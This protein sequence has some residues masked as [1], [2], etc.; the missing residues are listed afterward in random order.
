MADA[1]NREALGRARPRGRG[2]R[3]G[4]PVRIALVS[5]EF[6]PTRQAGGIAT[7]TEKTARA[8]AAAGHDVEVITE[9]HPEAPSDEMHGSLRVR[10][11]PDPG[12]RPREL[13][14]LRR[15]VDVAAALR[16]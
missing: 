6:P 10:R 14:V 12:A 1:G 9:A 15:A 8:L 5:R 3:G 2:R 4:R 16:R 13:K 7:Y 11:L